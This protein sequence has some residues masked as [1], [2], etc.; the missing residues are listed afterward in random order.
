MKR[1]IM[2]LLVAAFIT[3]G[4]A[5]NIYKKNPKDK[6]KIE[7]LSSEVE[8]L[9]ELREQEKKQFE[10]MKNELEKKLKGRVG[11]D[12]GER[13]LVITL[14]NNILFDSGKAKIKKE[15]YPILD[16]ITGVI[17][18][19]AIS[20]NIGVEGHTD[21]EPIKYSGWK[22]NR[23]LSTARANN[24]YHYLVEKGRIDPARLMTIGYGEFRAV[25]DN[26][27][28]E[29]RAKNRRVEI[30]ILP[31]YP[32]KDIEDIEKEEETEEVIPVK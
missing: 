22:S 7:E 13:G 32:R 1:I 2:L 27:T 20:K 30:V 19:K 28:P 31:Q 29:G 5:I 12:L 21:N 25:A 6:E 26:S 14:A 3:T 11:L 16:D 8:R 9:A 18:D 23:E 4:C 17:N 10:D 15:A 24:V